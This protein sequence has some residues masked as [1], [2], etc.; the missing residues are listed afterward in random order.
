MTV[1]ASYVTMQ[2][3]VVDFIHTKT[4]FLLCANKPNTIIV[5]RSAIY[6]RSA[7]AFYLLI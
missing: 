1:I 2:Y 4:P 7:L 3:I 6:D 5:T